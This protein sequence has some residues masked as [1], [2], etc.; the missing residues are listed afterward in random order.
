MKLLRTESAIESEPGG[1]PPKI[2]EVIC[3]L[4]NDTCTRPDGVHV[5]PIKALEDYGD[6]TIATDRGDTTAWKLRQLFAHVL[7]RY[8]HGDSPAFSNWEVLWYV[9]D[10]EF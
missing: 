6:K 1:K 5:I 3:G 9:Y 8:Y 10:M 4:S 2:L 7:F